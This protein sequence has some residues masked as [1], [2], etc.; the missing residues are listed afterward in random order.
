MVKE[1]INSNGSS[2]KNRS[3]ASSSLSSSSSHSSF[4]DNGGSIG[5][6]YE[7]T[8]STDE[9]PEEFHRAYIEKLRSDFL[10]SNSENKKLFVPST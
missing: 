9:D 4:E 6:N 5:H 8:T 3:R 1:P 7:T 2:G 10:A